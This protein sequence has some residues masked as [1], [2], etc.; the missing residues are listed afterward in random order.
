LKEVMIIFVYQRDARTRFC[1]S[2]RGFES[3]ESCANDDDMGE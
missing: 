1:K 3:C 2:T